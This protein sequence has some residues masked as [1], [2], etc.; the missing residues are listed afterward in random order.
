MIVY[1]K[2]FKKLYTCGKIE[3]HE[4]QS[5][6]YLCLPLATSNFMLFFCKMLFLVES[7]KS[8]MNSI[9]VLVPS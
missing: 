4:A 7:V 9:L 1:K 3:I 8:N 5:Q 6:F 2:C